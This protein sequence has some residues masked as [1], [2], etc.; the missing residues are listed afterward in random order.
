MLS[1]INLI[2]SIN[3]SPVFYVESITEPSLYRVSG[4]QSG[5]CR[6]VFLIQLYKDWRR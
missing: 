3:F 5:T 1:T 2:D 6:L 4:K